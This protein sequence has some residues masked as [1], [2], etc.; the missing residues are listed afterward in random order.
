VTGSN[1][2]LLSYML[3]IPNS[4]TK[5][6]TFYM[7]KLCSFIANYSDLFSSHDHLHPSLILTEEGHE[8]HL[9]D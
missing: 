5:F 9:I 6:N 4:P 3:N 1:P 7:S 2:E 8:K